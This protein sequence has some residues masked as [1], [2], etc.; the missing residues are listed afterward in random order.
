MGSN[1]FVSSH[2]VQYSSSNA[3]FG[4]GYK[5]LGATLTQL[6]VRLNSGGN[7]DAGLINIAYQL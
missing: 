7:Y 2:S 6:T 3:A 4:G 5:D 1:V